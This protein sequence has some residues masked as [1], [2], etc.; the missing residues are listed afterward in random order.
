MSDRESTAADAE[1]WL[2]AYRRAWTSNDPDD[3]RAAFTD[4]AEYRTE[5]FRAPISGH[6]AIV[7]SWLER[8]DEP[9]TWQFDARV[10]GVDGRRVFIQGETR[11]ASGTTYSNLWDVTLADDARARSFT[12]WWM[13][14][15]R[16]S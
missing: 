14:H 8:Q 15:A 10:V 3:I 2:D 5:P 11:Y 16:P 13:D 1:R 9:G 4:D 7:A 12:E 6:D